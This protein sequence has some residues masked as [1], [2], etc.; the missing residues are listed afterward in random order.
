MASEIQGLPDLHG[1][2]KSG[3]LVVRL[4]FPYIELPLKQPGFVARENPARVIEMGRRPSQ[5]GAPPVQEIKPRKPEKSK[6]VG[7]EPYFE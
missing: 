1:Y 4:R 7:Q 6:A 3:N 2:L 5:P